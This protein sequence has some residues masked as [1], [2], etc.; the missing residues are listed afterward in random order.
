MCSGRVSDSEE[1][2]E[3]LV[4]SDTTG[5]E[6]PPGCWDGKVQSGQEKSSRMKTDGGLHMA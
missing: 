3:L 2:W 1:E 4:A 5:D 6:V